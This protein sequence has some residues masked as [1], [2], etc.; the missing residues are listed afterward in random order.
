MKWAVVVPVGSFAWSTSRAALPVSTY[1]D[2]A[3]VNREETGRGL[4]RQAWGIL[5]KI[6]EVEQLMRQSQSAGELF[7]EVHPE[8]L[9]WALNGRRPVSTP[10]DV[11]RAALNGSMCSGVGSPRLTSFTP[12]LRTFT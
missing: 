10:N 4:S 1:E 2:V 11:R 5:P 9:F 7:V 8:L 12:M 6:R 3:R